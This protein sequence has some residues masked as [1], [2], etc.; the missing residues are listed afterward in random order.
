MIKGLYGLM[1]RLEPIF[2]EAIRH[3]IH[4]DFQEF[5]QIGLREP[6]RKAVKKKANSLMKS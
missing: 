4:K 6:V 2:S 1:S 3:S 5:I